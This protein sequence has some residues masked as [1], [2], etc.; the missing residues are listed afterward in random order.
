[1]IEFMISKTF[2]I[3]IKMKFSFCGEYFHIKIF[4]YFTFVLTLNQTKG[5][6]LKKLCQDNVLYFCVF[7]TSFVLIVAEKRVQK[8]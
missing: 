6:P 1:M 8:L 5:N 2:L 4:S 7:S 3:D